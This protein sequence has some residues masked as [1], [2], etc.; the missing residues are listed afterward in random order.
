MP[1]ASPPTPRSGWRGYCRR[2]SARAQPAAATW[3]ADFQH[4]IGGRRVNGGDY[5]PDELSW[6]I[7]AAARRETLRRLA[8]TLLGLSNES[9]NAVLNLAY[10]MRKLEGLPTPD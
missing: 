4:A 10:R 6:E 7:L 2:S 9:L 3:V 1:S 5:P 8:L